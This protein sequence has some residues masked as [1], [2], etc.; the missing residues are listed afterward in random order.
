MTISAG[1][2]Q[3]SDSKIVWI[4]AR[5]HP[6]ETTSSYIV[7][8]IINYLLSLFSNYT[9]TDDKFGIHN[10]TFKIV[11]MINVDGVIHGNTRG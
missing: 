7:E 5:Q 6:G 9:K 11:P 8:G 10:Y 1:E 3:L 4:L 2:K